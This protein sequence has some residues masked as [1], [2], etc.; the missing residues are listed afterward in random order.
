MTVPTTWKR[1]IVG[2]VAVVLVVIGVVL[3]VTGGE[4]PTGPSTTTTT[5]GSGQ[6]PKV[7]MPLENTSIAAVSAM[8]GLQVPPGVA[9]FLTAGTEDRTQLD[10]SFTLPSDQL[11]AFVTGSGFPALVEGTQVVTHSSPLWKLNPD[12][13]VSGATDSFAPTSGGAAVGRAVETVPEGDRVRVR[14][15]L[16]PAG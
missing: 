16:T 1:R 7:T 3:V 4:D 13:T 9:D 12:G 2:A 11:E 15:V 14:L 5:A 10:V 8:A 6:V